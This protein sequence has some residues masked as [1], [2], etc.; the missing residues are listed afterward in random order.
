MA[1]ITGMGICSALGCQ[2]D[3]VWS[4]MLKGETGINTL[5]VNHPLAGHGVHLLAQCEP[6]PL[7]AEFAGQVAGLKK[8]LRH[9]HGISQMLCYAA[10]K[11]LQ[12]AAIEPT[13]LANNPRV[14]L[15]VGTSSHL[16]EDVSTQALSERNPNWFLQTYANI[17]LAHLAILTGI[18]GPSHCIVNA[19]TSGSQTIG[20]GYKMLQHN[21][22]DIVIVA[23]C[24]SRISP[25]FLS[26]FSRLGM[27]SPG[28]EPAKGIQPFAEKR[29]GFVLGE[30]AAVLVMEQE[31][32]AQARRANAHGKVVGYGNSTDAHKLT[33]PSARG[34]YNAMAAALADAQ[35]ASTDIDYVNAHGTGT[36]MNDR[37]ESQAMTQILPHR[38]K[39][40]SSK[41]LLGHTLAASGVLE[42]I[43]CIQSLKTQQ[44]HPNLNL[45]PA[46]ADC[47]I[48]LVGDKAEAR[49]MEYCLNNSSAIGG[50]NTSLIFQRADSTA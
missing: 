48:N 25:S 2:V 17:H 30:G 39:V 6:P 35:L 26:G 29:N 18:S 27:H 15:L 34:K 8:Q 46:A 14:A 42:S 31:Q 11:A 20:L 4:R 28:Q 43:V 40:N 21:E 49:A 3:D 38:P 50:S 22:A 7:L 33:D 10:F 23:G 47:A 9:M 19:C 12:Q 16:C 5:P 37:T 32:H 44:L 24:D 41:S 13:T 1:V 36:K 45:T